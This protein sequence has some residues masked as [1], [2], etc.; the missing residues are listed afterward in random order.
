MRRLTA[1][2]CEGETLIAT[3][4][5]ALAASEGDIAKLQ[6]KLREARARQN[7]ITARL[8][9][10]NN[11]ARMREVYAGG[12]IDDAFAKFELMERRVDYAEGRAEAIP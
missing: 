5:E 3:L 4:D 11:R 12:K 1:V 6:A 8:E 2:P 9:S 7:S 10:A